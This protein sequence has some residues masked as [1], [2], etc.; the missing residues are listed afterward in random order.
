MKQSRFIRPEAIRG[1]YPEITNNYQTAFSGE[2]WYE[3]SKCADAEIDSD[4]LEA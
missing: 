1:N 4:A 2:P 3:V